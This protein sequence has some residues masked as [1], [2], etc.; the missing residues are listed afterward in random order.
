MLRCRR[1]ASRRAAPSC[2]VSIAAGAPCPAMQL[3]EVVRELLHHLHDDRNTLAAAVLVSRTW[4]ACGVDLLWREPLGSALDSI[5]APARRAFYANMT[6]ACERIPAAAAARVFTLVSHAPKQYQ[7][8]SAI[9]YKMAASHL[10]GSHRARKQSK[11]LNCSLVDCP[12]TL[13]FSRPLL[14]SPSSTSTTISESWFPSTK[15]ALAPS[16]ELRQR[17][18]DLWGH[19]RIPRIDVMER[20]PGERDG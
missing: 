13:P 11:S 7:G 5:D 17:H 14:T 15:A 12:A 10:L 2:I 1:I 8:A 9:L 19:V 6:V 16:D 18:E 3:P 20:S 4:F